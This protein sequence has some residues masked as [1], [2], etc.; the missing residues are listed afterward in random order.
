MNETYHT[1]FIVFSPTV[2]LGICAPNVRFGCIVSWTGSMTVAHPSKYFT[3]TLKKILHLLLKLYGMRSLRDSH[4]CVFSGVLLHFV[5]QTWFGCTVSWTGSMT[6]AH[7]SK[8]FTS[9]LKKILHPLLKLC[10]MRSLRDS[11]LCVFS[12][13]LL[14][15]VRQTYDL[16]AQFH[17]QAVWPWPAHQNTSQVPQKRSCIYY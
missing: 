2:V 17:E 15:F 9:T 10:G 12:G 3:S 16:V 8:Y 7:P 13:V 11:H 4:L 6:V 14:H 1:K 5:R